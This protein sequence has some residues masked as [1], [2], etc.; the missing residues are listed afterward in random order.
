MSFLQQ[1]LMLA[2]LGYRCSAPRFRRRVNSDHVIG[3]RAQEF[4]VTCTILC[5]LRRCLITIHINNIL[6]LLITATTTT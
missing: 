3:G 2:R 1:Q 6:S 4:Y 5:N